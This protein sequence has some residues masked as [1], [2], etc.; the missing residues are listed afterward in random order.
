[1]TAHHDATVGAD[2]A[3]LSALGDAVVAAQQP[4]RRRLSTAR[5]VVVL[6]IVAV[7]A[8]GLVWSAREFADRAEALIDDAGSDIDV[9]PYVD[10]T[11]TP[12]THFEDDVVNPATE[13]VLGF[14]VAAVDEPCTPT[15]GTFYDLDGAARALDL[16]RRLERHAERSGTVGVSFGGQAND[17]LAVVCDDVDAL[18]AAYRSVVDRYDATMIDLDV[19]GAALDDDESIIRRAEAIALLQSEPGPAVPVWLTLPVAPTGLTDRGVFVV[20]SML[21]AGVDLAG[22]NAMTMNYGGSRP[23]G[24]SM[25]A[26]S[27]DALEAVHR[28]LGTAFEQ[29]GRSVTD[30]ELWQRVGATPMVGRNDVDGDLFD[31]DDATRL[32]RFASSVDLGRLSYWSLNRDQTCGVRPDGEPSSPVCSGVEQHDL[33]FMFRLGTIDE[34]D[35]DAWVEVEAA[36]A[37]L[38]GAVRDDPAESPYPIWRQRQVYEAGTKVVW[39]KEVYVAKWWA[40]A[41]VM[42]GTPV[43]EP[44]DTPWRRLGPVLDADGEV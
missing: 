42:P 32:A 35:L 31:L 4:P 26:A 19:E 34:V 44:W 30:G 33:E 22:V 5:L 43:D 21:D 3:A 2:R 18:A 28:Q 12:I 17:E 38:D 10:V 27:I 7:A 11:L 15:W 29:V 23:Q 25:A 14:I 36:A 37:D 1:M 6:A 39:R 24:Q 8:S 40:D 9:A 20:D 16:D 13:V 41:D